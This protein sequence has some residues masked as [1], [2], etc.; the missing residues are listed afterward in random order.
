VIL[1]P[2]G[3]VQAIVAPAQTKADGSATVN[4][5][6]ASVGAWYYRARADQDDRYIA[7]LSAPVGAKVVDLKAQAAEAAAAQAAAD[8]EAARKAVG[9][10]PAPTAGYQCRDGDEEL[11]PVC[12]SHK[13]W[14]DG[15][16]ESAC[17]SAGRTWDIPTR[18]CR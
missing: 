2:A 17:I 15:Q 5:P 14:V 9:A 8:A 1:S 13:A 10:R 11:Y 7:A 4:V 3:R 12:A 16:R 6:A 18:E